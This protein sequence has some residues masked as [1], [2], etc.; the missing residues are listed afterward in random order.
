MCWI[1]FSFNLKQQYF[2]KVSVSKQ[3]KNMPTHRGRITRR[4]KAPTRLSNE[5][6]LFDTRLTAANW[7]PLSFPLTV[8]SC[9]SRPRY[10]KNK[11][12]VIHRPSAPPI[13]AKRPPMTV[14]PGR[15]RWT[16]HF[17]RPSRRAGAARVF[18]LG[19][20]YTAKRD[21]AA[22][23]FWFCAATGELCGRDC[24]V[25]GDEIVSPKRT[26]RGQWNDQCE[27]VGGRFALSATE[28]CCL[29]TGRMS[30]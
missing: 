3:T 23:L 1:C 13:N 26:G 17:A 7:F 10:L 18:W 15:M 24:N 19:W 8:F 29:Y 22:T 20:V 30:T 6:S 9:V 4:R 28:Q 16:T 27:L 14:R 12:Q 25:R 11:S 5:L 21:G 2:S